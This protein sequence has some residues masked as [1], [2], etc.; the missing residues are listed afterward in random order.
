[1]P[2][3]SLS[4]T[5]VIQAVATYLSLCDLWTPRDPLEVEYKDEYS[6][7]YGLNK[8]TRMWT[9]SRRLAATS[10]TLDLWGVLEDAWGHTIK[11]TNV[12]V[13]AIRNTSTVD[14]EDLLVGGAAANTWASMFGD[15]SDKLKIKPGVTLTISNTYDGYPVTSTTDQLKVDAGASDITYELVLI[16]EHSSTTSTSTSTSS[17]STMSP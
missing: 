10:E 11:F 9:D 1:M 15:V 16:G 13:I 5:V 2:R 6:N 7:G 12:K 4:T 17:T 8:A 14:G 3:T